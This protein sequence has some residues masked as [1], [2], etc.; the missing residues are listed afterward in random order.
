MILHKQITD[1]T[2]KSPLTLKIELRMDFGKIFPPLI[3]AFH[4]AICS[5]QVNNWHS[6]MKRVVKKA[7]SGLFPAFFRFCT[8]C[9]LQNPAICIIL[10]TAVI[11]YMALYTAI[12]PLTPSRLSGVNCFSR[13][14]N[15]SSPERIR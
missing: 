2:A 11:E 3:R 1:G 10:C 12:F 8:R 6:Q 13:P 4:A 15:A 14:N 5:S 7:V 9:F